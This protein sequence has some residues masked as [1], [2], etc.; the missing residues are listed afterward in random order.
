MTIAARE[1]LNEQVQTCIG[2]CMCRGT[3]V[4]PKIPQTVI[5]IYVA[6]FA[7]FPLL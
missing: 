2:F 1:T 3:I 7:S 4:Q 6:D 5:Y